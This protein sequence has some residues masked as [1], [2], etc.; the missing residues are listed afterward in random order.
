MSQNSDDVRRPDD[1][2]AA[3]NAGAPA[4]HRPADDSEEVYFEGSPL[5]RGEL[6]KA[7]VWFIL[8]LLLVAGP[9]VYRVLRHEWAPI[10]VTASLIVVGLVLPFIPLLLIRTVRYRIS[11]YRID[12][13]R[14]LLSKD[15]D[16][17]ELWHV[18][19][20]SFHQSLLDRILRV[21]TIT[22]VSHDETT[23]TLELRGLPK[24]RPLFEALKQR[25]IAVKRQRGVIKMDVG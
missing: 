25:V 12:Y 2:N 18:E 14:G 11:N 10:Y 8:G 24:P 13:E 3:P 5:L 1:A 20:I 22:V 23:P 4:P 16:T 19:D 17:L 15:I 21:G 7:G 9:I 6:G